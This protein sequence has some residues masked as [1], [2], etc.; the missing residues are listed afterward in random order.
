MEISSANSPK[1]GFSSWTII[2]AVVPSGNHG[3][4]MKSL[5]A[6]YVSQSI[7]E[8]V[9]KS[10]SSVLTM[11]VN[12]HTDHCFE[13]AHRGGLKIEKVCMESHL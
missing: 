8:Q 4:Q 13:Q 1:L 2:S 11:P 9:E 10:M 6:A 7:W 3:K 12:I 5:N